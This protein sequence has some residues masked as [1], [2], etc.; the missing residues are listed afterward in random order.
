[1][2]RKTNLTNVCVIQITLELKTI[3]VIILDVDTKTIFV[4]LQTII[5]HRMPPV[6]IIVHSVVTQTRLVDMVDVRVA[7][8]IHEG[9]MI[10]SVFHLL[11]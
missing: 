2:M 11:L 9:L 1:M 3:L 8:I 4:P 7:L 10:M 5:I 6:Y